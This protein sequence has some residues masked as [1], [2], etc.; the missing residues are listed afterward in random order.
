MFVKRDIL[1]QIRNVQTK[2][3]QQF[4]LSTV[5]EWLF[6]L[7][8]YTREN[9]KVYTHLFIEQLTQSNIIQLKYL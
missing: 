3:I 5:S 4:F 9:M 2:K 6:I 7:C 1:L 8:F